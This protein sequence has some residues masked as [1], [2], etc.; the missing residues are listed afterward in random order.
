[1]WVLNEGFQEGQMTID[2][3]IQE[4]AMTHGK[5]LDAQDTDYQELKSGIEFLIAAERERLL[6]EIN[7]RIGGIVPPLGEAC[8]CDK[9][10]E[11]IIHPC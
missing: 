1:L 10:V 4:W 5:V 9:R 8:N 2:A 7:L 3:V 11:E 6:K